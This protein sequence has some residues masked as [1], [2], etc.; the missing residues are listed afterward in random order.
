[1]TSDQDVVDALLD[2]VRR[3]HAAWINGDM[4]GYRLTPGA[5]IMGAFGG[6]LTTDEVA[7]QGRRAPFRNP[8]EHGSGEVELVA[9]GVSGSV[10]WLV[11]IE[12]AT[13]KFVGYD[14]P[15]R[16]AL[17]ATELFRLEGA[18]WVRFH[19]HADPLVE[20]HQLDEILDLLEST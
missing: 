19:R 8:W 20:F 18:N 13:V 14:E 12:Q 2:R 7:E 17:R 1:M 15:R 6:S 11:M 16:W 3:D 4:S 9:G 10:A 5:T